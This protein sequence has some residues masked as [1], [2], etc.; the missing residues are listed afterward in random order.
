MGQRPNQGPSPSLTLI[1][2][3]G[4][5]P[6]SHPA[7]KPERRRHTSRTKNRLQ[8]GLTGSNICNPTLIM[9]SNLAKLLFF[10]LRNS[11]GIV[12]LASL[13]GIAAG[14]TGAALMALFTTRLSNPDSP[15]SLWTL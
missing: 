6:A 15:T 4:R 5:S 1:L 8:N 12:V 13:A 7:A 3:A 9:N 11:K 10:L 14:V 2:A